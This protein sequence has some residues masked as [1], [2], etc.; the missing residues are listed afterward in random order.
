MTLP[1]YEV[2]TLHT[3]IESKITPSGLRS[4]SYKLHFVIHATTRLD[5]KEACQLLH[6]KTGGDHVC[7]RHFFWANLDKDNCGDFKLQKKW[8]SAD[9]GKYDKVGERYH[10]KRRLKKMGADSSWVWFVLPERREK[11]QMRHCSCW[12]RLKHD[13]TAYYHHLVFLLYQSV[14]A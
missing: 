3:V 12:I 4:V 7:P 2:N 6:N 9:K 1:C 10:C 5:L 14:A 8:N 13:P 11:V